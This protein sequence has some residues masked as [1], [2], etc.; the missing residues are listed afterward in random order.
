MYD[1]LIRNGTIID[2]DNAAPYRADVAIVG[3]EIVKI[4]TIDEPAKRVIDATGKIVTPGFIDIQRRIR[5]VC[6]RA[7][8]R[9]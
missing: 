7:S 8:Q 4:G 1:I 3:D 5:C 6:G 9:S 2:G